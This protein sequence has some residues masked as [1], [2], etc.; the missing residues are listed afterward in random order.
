MK[1]CFTLV[2]GMTLV[3]PLSASIKWN[4]KPPNPVEGL[5]GENVTLEWN[6]TLA[7]ENLDYFSLLRNYRDM[8][9]YSD[10]G[11]V[12][13][14]HFKGSVGMVKNGTPAFML[15][16]LKWSDDGTNFCC[17]VGTKTT[18]GSEGDTYVDCVALK[19]LGEM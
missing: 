7:N 14:K 9:K 10:V 17:K 6:F 1:S 3:L 8:I 2:L 13:Y 4:S 19:V 15:I 5:L 16:N 12:I 18:T 11:F